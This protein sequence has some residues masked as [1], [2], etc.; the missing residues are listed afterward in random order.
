M[1]ALIGNDRGVKCHDYTSTNRPF[2]AR[3]SGSNWIYNTISSPIP[4]HPIA[5]FVVDGTLVVQTGAD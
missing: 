5:T 1:S 3:G 2:P 4:I